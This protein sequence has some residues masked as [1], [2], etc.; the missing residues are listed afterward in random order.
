MDDFAQR[1]WSWLQRKWVV[2]QRIR[3]RTWRLATPFAAIIGSILLGLG[4]VL[5]FRDILGFAGPQIRDSLGFAGPTSSTSGQ[6]KTIP[7]IVLVSGGLIGSGFILALLQD[8]KE[9]PELIHKHWDD[10][11]GYHNV[12]KIGGHV[13]A[14]SIGVFILALSVQHSELIEPKERT[15]IETAGLTVKEGLQELARSITA[16]SSVPLRIIVDANVRDTTEV[17]N[18]DSLL[19]E[20]M[21]PTSF[22][23]TFQGEASRESIERQKGSGVNLHEADLRLLDSLVTDLSVC[24]RRDPVRLAVKGYASSSVYR[25]SGNSDKANLE[26]AHTRAE[27]VQAVLDSLAASKGAFIHV[28]LHEWENHEAMVRN[29]HYVD[30]V[31]KAYSIQKG[32]LNRRVEIILTDAGSC[33]TRSEIT[34]SVASN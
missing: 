22:V 10:E 30:R 3:I 16:E 28:D 26:V 19:P 9:I 12:V 24:G 29:R 14:A 15:P 27:K 8:L 6:G 2:V 34:R 7:F 17:R 11:T 20:V 25:S 23:I 4:V 21:R 13:F 33:E 31:G 5:V 32:R 1:V 18:P